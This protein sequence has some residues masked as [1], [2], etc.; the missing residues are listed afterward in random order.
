[1][2]KSEHCNQPVGSSTTTENTP[3]VTEH[4][5][6]KYLERSTDRSID[7]KTAWRQGVPIGLEDYNYDSTR[8]HEPTETIILRKGPAMTTVLRS[9]CVEINDDHLLECETCGHLYNKS[10]S[11]EGCHHC[12]K[13]N[14]M[15]E[16]TAYTPSL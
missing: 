16:N 3:Y 11:D 4:A 2:S 15:I 12:G 8:L 14:A 1:M 13:S 7:I 9:P 10:P 5:D 6:L